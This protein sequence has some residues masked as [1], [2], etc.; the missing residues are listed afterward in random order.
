[1]CQA[2]RGKIKGKNRSS[3]KRGQ[4]RGKTWNLCPYFTLTYSA[5]FAGTYSATLVSKRKARSS[6]VKEALKHVK[7]I[8]MVPGE[9]YQQGIPSLFLFSKT[10]SVTE[11]IDNI[12]VVVYNDPRRSIH[13]DDDVNATGSKE[14]PN[15][16]EIV[17]MRL[18]PKLKQISV[19]SYMA[20]KVTVSVY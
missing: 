1:M 14:K 6:F 11:S 2:K 16:L 5:T 8:Q 10:G 15:T 7:N 17:L 18:Y 12:S 9:D 4:K 19:T 13:E 3:V 20:A